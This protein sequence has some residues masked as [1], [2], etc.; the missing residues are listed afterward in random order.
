MIVQIPMLANVCIP[1]R[2]TKRELI[3]EVNPTIIARQLKVTGNHSS[4]S[5]A[6]PKTC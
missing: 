1:I 4:N 6:S 2:I 3:A 5:Y